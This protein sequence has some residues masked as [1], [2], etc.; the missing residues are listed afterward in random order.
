MDRH[1][2]KQSISKVFVDSVRIGTASSVG[3]VPE[4][5]LGQ[6]RKE[7]G[8]HILFFQRIQG[9]PVPLWKG[10]KI[11]VLDCVSVSSVIIDT[12]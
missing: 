4:R 5:V 1:L 2:F 10:T 8:F 6:E 12:C 3:K 9:T 7:E 11:E